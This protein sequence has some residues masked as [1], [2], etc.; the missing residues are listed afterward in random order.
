MRQLIKTT[1]IGY[2]ALTNREAI[3]SDRGAGAHFTPSNS[4]VEDR[5]RKV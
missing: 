3:S 5:G 1:K 2:D 4:D